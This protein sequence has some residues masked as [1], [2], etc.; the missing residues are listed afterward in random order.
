MSK[1]RARSW[2]EHPESA[3][4]PSK[5]RRIQE[6]LRQQSLERDTQFFPLPD[7]PLFKPLG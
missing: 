1:S 5:K 7:P 3:K 2:P 4:R 6:R